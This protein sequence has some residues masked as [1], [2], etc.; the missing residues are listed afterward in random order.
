MITP[1]L[2]V[3]PSFLPSFLSVRTECGVVCYTLE[4]VKTRFL[5]KFFVEWKS[6]G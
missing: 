2:R 3:R 4:H 5:Q 1:S 6:W